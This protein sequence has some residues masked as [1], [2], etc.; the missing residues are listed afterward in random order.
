MA[1][2]KTTSSSHATG[3]KVRSKKRS[4][5]IDMTPMVDL[6]F[7]LL[8]FFLMTTT[9]NKPSVMQLT[10]P[11]PPEDPALLPELSARN[12]LN[13]VLAE[14]NRLYV[15]GGEDPSAVSSDYSKDGIRKILLEKSRSNPQLMVLIKPMDNARYENMVDILDEVE[16]ANISRYAIVEF[17]DEDMVKVP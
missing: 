12:A 16:I 15:W 13:I 2:I 8:T 5:R 9:F 6:A 17:T 3:A 10:M 11:E 4:T 7:L 14:D 1:D